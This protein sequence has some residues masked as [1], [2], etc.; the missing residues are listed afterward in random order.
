MEVFHKLLA[1]VSFLVSLYFFVCGIKSGSRN[2]Q[3][4]LYLFPAYFWVAYYWIFKR[5]LMKKTLTKEF[6]EEDIVSLHVWFVLLLFSVGYAMLAVSTWRDLIFALAMLIS[7]FLVYKPISWIY[8]TLSRNRLLEY[9]IG[10][11]LGA[12]VLVLLG[13]SL[14]FNYLLFMV[15]VWSAMKEEL[16]KRQSLKHDKEILCENVTY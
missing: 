12:L 15:G 1:L 11:G 9:L 4:L 13:S 10:F 5:E 2:L 16:E 3:T 6:H 14:G 7:S 8:T